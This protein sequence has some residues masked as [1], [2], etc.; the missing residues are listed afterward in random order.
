MENQGVKYF[1]REATPLNFHKF[2]KYITCPFSI[3]FMARNIWEVVS[4]GSFTALDIISQVVGITAIVSFLIT[5]IDWQPIAWKIVIAYCV[6]L[7]ISRIAENT[8]IFY[9]INSK[10]ISPAKEIISQLVRNTSGIISQI[11]IF[12]YYFKRKNLFTGRT[13]SNNRDLFA[14]QAIEHKSVSKHEIEKLSNTSS[15]IS[16]VQEDPQLRRDSSQKGRIDGGFHNDYDRVI[17]KTRETNDA[18]VPITNSKVQFCRKCGTR[19]RE[20]ELFCHKCG[21]SF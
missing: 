21:T 10:M 11:L 20:G 14:K 8:Y 16:R 7:V 2:F 13:K 15:R 19:I 4:S 9:L 18:T 3:L 17:A 1:D 5:S 12:I 6:L